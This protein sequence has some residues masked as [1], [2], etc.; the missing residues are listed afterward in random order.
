MFYNIHLRMEYPKESK[1]TRRTTG[2]N[3]FYFH[4]ASIQYFETFSNLLNIL[5]NVTYKAFYHLEMC[6]IYQYVISSTNWYFITSG[7]L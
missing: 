7:A 4:T 6:N 2:K 3:G 1:I 5:L